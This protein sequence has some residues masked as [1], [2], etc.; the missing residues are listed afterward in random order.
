M[1]PFK[2]LDGAMGSELIRRGLTLPEHTWSA[3]ANINYPDMVQKIHWEYL[4]AGADYIT[5]NTFR[6]TPRAYEKTGIRSKGTNNRNREAARSSLY[7]A[8]ELAKETA[9]NPVKVVGSIAPLEDCYSPELFPGTDTAMEEFFQLG[10]WLTEAGV[11]IL[12]LETMN[13]VIE[14]EAALSSIENFN[15]PIWV[16]FVLKDDV[17]LLSGDS[18]PQAIEK[19]K[20]HSIDCILFNCNPLDRTL[21]AAEN[22]VHSW[23]H[24]WGVYPNLGV[25]EA[26]PNGNILHCEEMD[27]FLS[28][29]EKII[30]LKPYIIGA[31]CGSSPEHIQGLNN[32]QYKYIK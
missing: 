22:L 26:S 19:M 16:S 7:K 30:M 18:I 2:I 11:D 15:L 24:K 32:L 17:H 27:Y 12:L 8:V 23:P 25:G 20:D 10:E 21:M 3:D 1:E 4:D 5:T 13:S 14:T 6:T 29:M 9:S 28:I 31:C